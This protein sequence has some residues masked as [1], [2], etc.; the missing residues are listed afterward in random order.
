MYKRKRFESILKRLKEKRLF[1]QALIGPRQSGKTTLSKQLME[2]LAIPSHYATADG[3]NI[4]SSNWI[5]QQWEAASLKLKDSKAK[6]LLLV[7]DEI[8]KI[9]DWTNKVKYLWDK[10]TRDGTNIK[11]FIL[12]SS[13]LLVLKGLNESMAGRFEIIDI[14]HWSFEE[15]KK[16][17]GFSL[18]E[19]IFFGG[20]PG[21]EGL[22]KDEERWVKYIKESLIETT[23]SR[24]VLL[25]TRIDKPALLRRL[26]ELGCHY[27]GQILSYNKMLGQ[28]HDAGNTTTLA[29]YLDL[30]SSARMLTGLHKF[31]TKEIQ[32][33]SSSPKL[34]VMNT[35]LMSAQSDLKF[36]EAFKDKIFWGRLV[37][38]AVG[39]HL[40]N[41]I[42]GSRLKLF[43]WRESNDE[44]DF[45]LSQGQKVTAI[46]VTTQAHKMKLSG[47]DAFSNRF[48][49]T[50][51]LLVGENGIKL[52]EF[53][54]SN[55][56]DLI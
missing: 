48:R 50:K 35:A 6:E 41:S 55:P 40:L 56:Q 13:P 43:Y 25:L 39:S 51:K 24:D 10:D 27:S 9:P 17:F 8:Q 18:E 15:M 26:F 3:P 11:L 1:I 37:E 28:L 7:I 52:E 31:S 53:L 14:P 16:A 5:E 33:R 30:L 49:V 23:I 22:I 45:I 38:S 36:E 20:Y 34:L 12:G 47:I 21:A 2:E 32:K 29:H 19:Y 46:E 42:M 4:P 44:V 54:K